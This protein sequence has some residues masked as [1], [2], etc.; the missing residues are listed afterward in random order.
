[1]RLDVLIDFWWCTLDDERPEVGDLCDDF[2]AFCV[3]TLGE[4][5]LLAD[6]LC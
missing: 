1:M 5:V 6:C 2:G 3:C 4:D